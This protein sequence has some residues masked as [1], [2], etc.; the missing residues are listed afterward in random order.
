VT[1][2]EQD[3]RSFAFWAHREQEYN[4]GP[5]SDHLEA[6][7]RV[8]VEAG[9]EGAILSAAFLHDVLEDTRIET[10][11]L[12]DRFGGDVADLV[13]AVAG[14]GATRRE[15]NACI[16]ARLQEIP[17]AKDL[18][19]ADRVANL[20]ACNDRLRAMY[21]R[22]H[23]EFLRAVEGSSPALL[24][25]LAAAVRTLEARSAPEDLAE[26]VREACAQKVEAAGCRCPEAAIAED[27]R[28]WPVAARGLDGNPVSLAGL[29]PPHRHVYWCP[30]ALAEAL[31]RQP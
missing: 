5:Y 17:V 12:A 30:F 28:T 15:R 21:L 27:W 6:V 14:E 16:Y 7:H 2:L 26:K 8:L 1:P 20:E 24:L 10:S 19:V 13:W 4:G 23:P 25:R 29:A 11:F 18:K 31:R 3:A 22:E 9:F